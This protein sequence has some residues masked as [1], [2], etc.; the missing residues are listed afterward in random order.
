MRSHGV[1]ELG[2]VV[3]LLNDAN[4][5][6]RNLLVELYVALELVDDRARKRFGF[7]LFA[8]IVSEDHGVG[9]EIF[10]AVGV[11]V[12][13]GARGALDQHFDRA[14]GQLEQLQDT[15]ERPG[16]ENRVRRRIVIGGVLLR[17]EQD[18][19]VG[20]HHLFQRLDRLFAPNEERNDHVREDD[21]VAQRQDR[22]G[23]GLARNKRRLWLGTGHSPNSLLLCPSSATRSSGIPVE[24]R[25]L[26]GK[27]NTGGALELRAPAKV[28]T[29]PS[30]REFRRDPSY[31]FSSVHN[32]WRRDAIVSSKPGN[33]SK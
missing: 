24:C 8:R 29:K 20:S 15:R 10:G 16:L 14:V 12:D 9:L 31:A 19:R 25:G 17:R 1:G 32:R 27:E 28:D 30:P 33:S 5:F 23:P 3:D 6:R 13:L 21:D 18:E 11:L 22:I 7:D 4:D 26:A 2:V